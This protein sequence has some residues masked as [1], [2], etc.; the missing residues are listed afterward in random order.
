MDE[1]TPGCVDPGEL[2]EVLRAL[3]PHHPADPPEG[4]TAEQVRLIDALLPQ[5]P[6]GTLDW[7]SGR[8]AG[9][10]AS[11]PT[12]CRG[13][14][15]RAVR[16]SKPN[17]SRPEEPRKTT[18]KRYCAFDRLPARRPMI[19]SCATSGRRRREVQ[20]RVLA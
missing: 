11:R 14:S 3:V 16:S 17:I 8:N 2:L 1:S 9:W 10:R 20:V 12:T 5:S 13:C 7:E 19:C 15:A 4:T 6:S 18:T